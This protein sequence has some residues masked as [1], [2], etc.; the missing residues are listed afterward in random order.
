MTLISKV[1]PQVPGSMIGFSLK[2]LTSNR[3]YAL[4]GCENLQLPIQLQL[5]EKSKAFSHF[6]IPFLESISNFKLFEKNMIVTPIVL[7]KLQTVNILVRPL[8][9]KRRF[10]A[11]FDIEH[12]KASL[13]T[14]QMSMR[15]L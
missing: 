12:V 7:P 3:K 5:S 2:T 8:S 14:C 15:V 9:K 4:E 10:R 13:K 6:F 11:H 1:S